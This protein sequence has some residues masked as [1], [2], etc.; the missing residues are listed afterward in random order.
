MASKN[1]PPHLREGYKCNPPPIPVFADEVAVV[2]SDY[3][4]PAL[5]DFSTNRG[6]LKVKQRSQE[7]FNVLSHFYASLFLSILSSQYLQL[8]RYKVKQ[9]FP[10]ASLQPLSQ[11]LPK[12]PQIPSQ[13]QHPLNE[14]Q[15]TSTELTKQA[16]GTTV[17][18]VMIRRHR[19]LLA[20][21][22]RSTPLRR[23]RSS[24][25]QPNL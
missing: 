6:P 25:R 2:A 16:T 11:N 20:T 3:T 7:V 21:T 23:T 9:V 10:T 22:S 13:Q 1:V 24:R 4:R 12:S 8:Y 19:L 14:I 18:L 5:R 17:G 15:E